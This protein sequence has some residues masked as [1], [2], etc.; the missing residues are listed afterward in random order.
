MTDLRAAIIEAA[1]AMNAERINRG[2]AGN[3]SA[4]DGTGF[5]ITPSAVPYDELRPA[6]IVAV[7]SDGDAAPGRKPS[8]EWR[9]HRDVYAARPDVG[10]VVHAH[11]PFATALACLHRDIPPFH[12]MV[13]VAGGATIRCATYATFGTQALSDHVLVALEGRRAC[14]LANH[15]MVATGPDLGAALRL[16]VEVESLAEMYCLALQIGTPELLS[17]DQ[18]TEALGA[19]GGYGEG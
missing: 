16:A 13:A 12:Y 3:V 8:S 7:D 6:D 19:F 4:R 10:A 14:L 9:I 18:M 15:G 11:P 1:Q 2:M 17:A 5:L